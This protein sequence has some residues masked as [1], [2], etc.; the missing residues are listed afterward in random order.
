MPSFLLQASRKTLDPIIKIY[1]ATIG[2]LKSV[3]IENLKITLL[4]P[5]GTKTNKNA[6][7]VFK[8]KSK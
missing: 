4:A 6:D 3:L 2:F 5:K 1:A 8:I 7:F